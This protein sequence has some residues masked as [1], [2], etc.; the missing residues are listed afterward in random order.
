MTRAK[1]A[2]PPKPKLGRPS[3]GLS[4]T[5]VLIRLPALLK[6][7]VDRL[8]K[9]EGIDSSEWWRR[10]ARVRAGWDEIPG[11]TQRLVDATK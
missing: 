11:A 9:A 10:A 5:T 2:T 8:A 4:E 7:E 3:R 1:K 6:L